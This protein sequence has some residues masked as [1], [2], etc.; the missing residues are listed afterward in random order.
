MSCAASVIRSAAEIE[1]LETIELLARGLLGDSRNKVMSG[2][3]LALEFE[4]SKLDA[5]RAIERAKEPA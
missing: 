2:P 5:M 1:R 4:F 3:R